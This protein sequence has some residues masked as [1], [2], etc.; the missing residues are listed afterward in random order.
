MRNSNLSKT[1]GSQVSIEHQG[2]LNSAGQDLIPKQLTQTQVTLE[3]PGDRLGFEDECDAHEA[4]EDFDEIVPSWLMNHVADMDVQNLTAVPSVCETMG[5]GWGFPNITQFDEDWLNAVT[6]TSDMTRVTEMDTSTNCD[7]CDSTLRGSI[8]TNESWD[9]CFINPPSKASPAEKSSSSHPMSTIIE[10]VQGMDRINDGTISSLCSNMGSDR[11]DTSVASER[12]DGVVTVLTPTHHTRL[13]TLDHFQ[14]SQAEVTRQVSSKE[15]FKEKGGR[16]KTMFYQDPPTARSQGQKRQSMLLQSGLGLK[17][18]ATRHDLEFSRFEL[19]ELP[20]T[21]S[22]NPEELSAATDETLEHSMEHSSRT[23]RSFSRFTAKAVPNLG[24]FGPHPLP[25]PP[26]C[27]DIREDESSTLPETELQSAMGFRE[28]FYR[29]ASSQ[30]RPSSPVLSGSSKDSGFAG[31]ESMHSV[32]SRGG[33]SS[34]PLS[35][36]KPKSILCGDT[37]RNKPREISISAA[38]PKVLVY[39]LNCGNSIAHKAIVIMQSAF[40]VKF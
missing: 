37:G 24:D 30:S 8:F 39:F 26:K 27:L 40:V 28:V 32:R 9:P 13:Q 33:F 11:K 22:V 12:R 38:R 21:L 4:W 34:R 20:G 6:I 31:R 23:Y 1:S 10:S 16:S 14:I 3:A 35:A 36:S 15:G 19:P 25:P 5:N 29:Q 18:S 17:K 7:F 2:I